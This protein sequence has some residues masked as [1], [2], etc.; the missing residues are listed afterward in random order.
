MTDITASAVNV[1]PTGASTS[2]A[3]Y[4]ITGL[5]APKGVAV[6]ANYIYVSNNGGT[7]VTVYPIGASTATA[8]YTISGLN[9]PWGVA[10][11]ANHVYV[12]NSGGTTVTVYPIGASTAT[13]SYTISGLTSPHNVAVDTNHIYV[14]D[15][16]D[17]TVKVYPIGA[18]TSTA[19]Y[20]IS[21][22]N[23]P[24]GVAVDANYIY[25]ANFNGN[26][27]TVYPIGASTST[28]SYTISSINQ[29]EGVALDP[30][31]TSTVRNDNVTYTLPYL[32]TAADKP[33]YCLITNQ[34]NDNATI[35]F[36]VN[37]NSSGTANATYQNYN[38][39]SN[40]AI[41]Y[42]RQTRMLSFEGLNINLDG[43]VMGSVSVIMS[44]GSYG[45]R[46]GLWQMGTLGGSGSSNSWSCVD[47]PMA[48]F[49]GTT[50]PKR[51][52]VGYMCS[53]QYSPQT[54]VQHFTY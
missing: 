5:N 30:S 22:L 14:T 50:A 39:L 47:L 4:S 27:V 51:N 23:S 41:I 52:L 26:T 29:P 35:H 2:T 33:I 21:G 11:D 54:P 25:V 34:T 20:T 16:G 15:A 48:C 38:T 8:S 36:T 24:R 10:V 32:T 9:S 37:A 1:Y 3:S 7:T 19:S 49:Q 28:A 44:S 53:D 6:D 45:G 40:Y 17:N 43:L 18:S 42:A 13:A 31:T 46:I 12:V